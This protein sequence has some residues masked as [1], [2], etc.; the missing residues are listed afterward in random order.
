MS[1]VII[2]VMYFMTILMIAV[3]AR[4]KYSIWSL[5]SFPFLAFDDQVFHK[6]LY[7]IVISN[8]AFSQSAKAKPSGTEQVGGAFQWKDVLAVFPVSWLPYLYNW[9]NHTWKESL[10]IK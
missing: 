9:N 4:G 7:C 2:V 5:F 3:E 1:H 10:Y 8:Y 6:L